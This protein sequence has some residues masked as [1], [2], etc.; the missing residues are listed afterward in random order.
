MEIEFR[1][2]IE[3]DGIDAET[4]HVYTYEKYQERQDEKVMDAD[5]PENE[6]LIKTEDFTTTRNLMRELRRSLNQIS[7][8]QQTSKNRLKNHAVVG[9]HA[10][11]KM[12]QNSILVT[13]LFIA[14]TAFQVYTIT[15]WFNTGNASLL[16][17]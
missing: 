10:Q 11:K 4:N 17:R 2:T 6:P 12:T 15:K 5:K 16:A 8:L 3:L 13:I 9:E 7:A 1:T 14:T